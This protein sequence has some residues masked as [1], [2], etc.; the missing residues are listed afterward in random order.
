MP[1]NLNF[2]YKE[3]IEIL[4]SQSPFIPDIALILGSGLGNFVNSLHLEKSFSTNELP[5]YPPST[6]VGHQGKIHFAQYSGKKLLIF[7]GRIHL[8][9]GYKIWECILP[10]FLA[11][12]MNTKYLLLTNAAGGV[13]KN[14]SPGDFMLA[15]SFNGLFI[16]NE[17]MKL[18]GIA[19]LE[20]KNNFLRLPS[21]SLNSLIKKASRE[22]SLDLKEGVYWYIKGPSYETPA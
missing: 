4:E 14:F 15:T 8:Y 18:I 20:G 12:K 1:I 7:Q 6:I 2:K 10:V 5:G 17:L 16:K 22:I 21:S 13:N 19:S 11:Y 3:L 9:E